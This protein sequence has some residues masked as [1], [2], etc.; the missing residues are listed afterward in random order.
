M[1]SKRK[2]ERAVEFL[3][4]IPSISSD[5][6]SDAINQ[7]CNKISNF[8]DS[9]HTK[10]NSYR[11]YDVQCWNLVAWLTR[12]SVDS[13]VCDSRHWGVCLSGR[14]VVEVFGFSI[15]QLVFS[16]SAWTS[17]SC[18]WGPWTVAASACSATGSIVERESTYWGEAVSLRSNNQISEY[19]FANLSIR[20]PGRFLI[21]LT[22]AEIS[23]NQRIP[24][25]FDT[26]HREYA[27]H[28]LG[29]HNKL[30]L[31]SQCLNH[32]DFLYGQ[33]ISTSTRTSVHQFFEAI[34]RS[35]ART[36]SMF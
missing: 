34:S 24:Q 13:L 10:F 29:K 18:S 21:V 12:T 23:C 26:T 17:L 36:K 20:L 27:L 4:I 11:S 15:A 31:L 30:T 25:Q 33:R 22:L 16:S 7:L 14:L 35:T 3:Y 1:W 6:Y 32:R 28:Q 5:F 2:S 9:I 19:Y 8:G